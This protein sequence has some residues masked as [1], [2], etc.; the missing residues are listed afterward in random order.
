[1]WD[2]VADYCRDDV[3]ATHAVFNET[4]GDYNARKILSELS[5]LSMNATTNQHSAA[6]IF[7]G[8]P[9]WETDKELVYTDLSE[10]FPGYE[11]SYGKST[12]RDEEPGEGGYVHA[13]PGVYKKVGLYDAVSMHPTTA[14]RLN[15]FGKYTA[16]LE[17]LV[18]ARVDI[19]EEI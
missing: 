4:K 12:Y 15:I 13:E 7:E 8:R 5:G 19:K 14:I 3:F 2:I 1:M 11:Y 16:I 17:E 10:E 18:A 9:K 6:I